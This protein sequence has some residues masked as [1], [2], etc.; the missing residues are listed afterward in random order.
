MMSNRFL[1]STVLHPLYIHSGQEADTVRSGMLFAFFLWF[2]FHTEFTEYTEL[3]F[4]FSYI[5][6]CEINIMLI[7]NLIL[8]SLLSI[9]FSTE[10]SI[11]QNK[12]WERGP[13]S[14]LA[15]NT[16]K[17]PVDS[18]VDLAF[19]TIKIIKIAEKYIEIEFSIVNKGNVSAPLFGRT[20]SKTDNVAIHFYFSGT[21]RMT[22][23][24]IFADGIYLTKGLKETKGWLTPNEVYTERIKLSLKKRIS[25]YGVILLQLDAFDILRQECD[26]TDNVKPITPRWY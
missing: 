1:F 26:E 18:C 5:Y 25:F 7:K 23:G 2:R 8:F 21:N 12:S 19:D 20:K 4:C 11:I 13:L 9:F 14:I 3:S 10:K 24:A 15:K 16:A 17:M 22:R 6:I